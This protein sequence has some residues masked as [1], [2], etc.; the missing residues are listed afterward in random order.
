MGGA[1]YSSYNTQP[2]YSAIMP[3]RELMAACR[4]YLQRAPRDFITYEYC[5]LDGVNDSD[6]HARA[7]VQVRRALLGA[8]LAL[9]TAGAAAPRAR[10]RRVSC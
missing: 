1:L 9:G 6:E 7:L 3:L 5:M 8:S 10:T 4:R 2:G